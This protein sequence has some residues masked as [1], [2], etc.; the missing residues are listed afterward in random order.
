MDALQ[1]E[2]R[3][4]RNVDPRYTL[5]EDHM[6]LVELVAKNHDH[7]VRILE[8]QNHTLERQDKAL[9]GDEE[10]L[11]LMKI[12]NKISNHIDVVCNIAKWTYHAI[13]AILALAAPAYTIAHQIGWL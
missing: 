1:E 10:N 13:L 7:V 8:T 6:R 5:K 2:Q 4:R 12:A 3:D 9:F 11:G